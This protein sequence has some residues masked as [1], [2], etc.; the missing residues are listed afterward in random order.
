[1]AS[2]GA[3]EAFTPTDVLAAVMTMRGS[4]GSAKTKAHE[5]LELFQKSVRPLRRL[6]SRP[7][8]EL[9]LPS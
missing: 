2:N 8:L 9:T 1:M 4:D 7:L 5:Y 6:L 3:Q